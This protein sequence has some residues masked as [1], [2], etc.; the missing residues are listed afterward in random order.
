MTRERISQWKLGKIVPPL[1]RSR[2]RIY[3]HDQIPPEKNPLHHTQKFTENPSSLQSHL[4]RFAL[5]RPQSYLVVWKSFLP[6]L[7]LPI[8]IA[9]LM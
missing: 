7:N 4:V 8:S 3:V 9:D 6:I 1:S 2:P 5:T